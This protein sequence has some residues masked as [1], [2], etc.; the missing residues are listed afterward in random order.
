M[1]G[2]TAAFMKKIIDLRWLF[3]LGGVSLVLRKGKL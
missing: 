2:G 3:L 1:T